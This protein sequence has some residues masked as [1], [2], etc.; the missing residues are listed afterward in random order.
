MN[1]NSLYNLAMTAN[2]YTDGNGDTFVA[3]ASS[4]YSS[5]AQPYVPFNGASTV[6]DDCWHPTRG[7][8]QWLKLQLPVPARI[9]GFTLKNRARNVEHPTAI[10]FQGSN[11]DTNWDDLGT[12]SWTETGTNL[13]KQVT[14]PT[15]TTDYLYF[16]WYITGVTSS[17]Y[18][19]I[20]NIT[21]TDVLVRTG[22]C[23]IESQGDY[24]T[25]VNDTLTNVGSTLDAQLFIDYGMDAVPNWSDY[26]SLTDP[27][28]LCWNADE[29]VSLTAVTT[30]VP[31]YP[32]TVVSQNIE[33]ISSTI[34]GVDS[35]EIDCDDDTLFA[36]SFDD[37]S[38]W[39][40]YVNNQ[41]VL[42]TTSTAGQ[43]KD[44]IEDIP[45]NAWNAKVTNRQLM[46]RFTLLDENGYV[47][48]IK[49]NYTN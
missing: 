2:T 23:L 40:N 10:T 26:S 27:S 11:D 21:F 41:W 37:G 48:Q 8:P 32:Q 30:G 1:A 20:A 38:T 17:P 7:V 22:K 45:T 5:G 31:T 16:R 35:V 49:V 13:V 4:V 18:G 39:Y 29:A 19:V 47:T 46:F 33:M 6:G 34:T 42:L 14:I 9:F 15:Y 36:M 43:T 12:I 24:Y 44:S 3:S 28:I 25:L